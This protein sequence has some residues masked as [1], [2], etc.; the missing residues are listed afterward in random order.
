MAA[1]VTLCGGNVRNIMESFNDV[2]VTFTCAINGRCADA[3]DRSLRV[4][5]GSYLFNP[6]QISQVDF[7]LSTSFTVR[8]R[9]TFRIVSGMCRANRAT[10]LH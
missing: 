9:T 7:L 10:F 4:V 6:P 1:E 5:E 2:R 3:T 8:A